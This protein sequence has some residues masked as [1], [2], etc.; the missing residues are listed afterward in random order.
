[1][2]AVGT[3]A[4]TLPGAAAG[5]GATPA[6]AL[7]SPLG[8]TADAAPVPL[9]RRRLLPAVLRSDP[10]WGW[11]GPL[12]VTVLAGVLRMWRLGEPKSILFDETYYAKDGYSLL[13]HGYVRT[14][15]E[16]ANE[17][18]VAGDT[19]DIFTADPAKVVHPEVGKWM[20]AAGE[21]I[22]GMDPFGWRFAAAVAGTLTVLVLARLVRRLT[23]STL[24]GCVAGLLLC[25]D[26]LHFVMS[27]LALLDIFMTFWLV[28]AVACLVADRDWG[29]LRLAR[30]ADA[31]VAPETGIGPVRQL[32]L[33]PWRIGAGVCFGL[34]CGTKWSAVYV[35]AAFGLLVWAWDAGARRTIGV[36]SPVAASFVAD[37]I[38]ALFSI[39]GVGLVVYVASWTGWLVHAGE[40]EQTFGAEW[41][42]YA[43]HDADGL[44]GE[45]AQ[46]LRSLWHCHEDVYDF[47]TGVPDANGWT[48][49]DA[50]HPYMSH[51]GGWPIVNRPVGVDV[52]LDIKPGDQGCTAAA[53]DTCLRQILLIG[54]P[55]LWWASTLA[56]IAGLVFWVGRRDWR[57]G[58]AIAGFLAAWVPWFRYDDRPIFY[59]Y[60]VA[61]VPFMVIGLTLVLGYILGPPDAGARRRMWGAAIAGTTVLLVIANFAF[62]YPL[63]TDGLITHAQW[64]MRMWFSR[65]I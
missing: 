55:V 21:G 53:D 22:F 17:R 24:L 29:R 28:C 35:L 33:R 63:Y 47:H 42:A 32:L 54:T 6:T 50:T 10:L 8:R 12:L 15:V 64:M 4:D 59:Y 37:A 5:S 16:K 1:M 57:F 65:W 26:G 38:P 27:R 14:F 18:I 52:E 11:L 60:A 31:S 49:L 51:P 9:A 7:R 48:I 23:G 25:F 40:Y 2:A 41:G 20:I 43:Q 62:F 30:I 36:R 34:A 3:T 44:V 13:E 61:M 56:L 39:V 45:T 58:V 19:T 46:S